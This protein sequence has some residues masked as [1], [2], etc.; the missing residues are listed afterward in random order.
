MKKDPNC[1]FCKIVAGEIPS[2][3]IA[4]N[5]KFLAILDIAQF[6]EGHTIVI[7]KKHY[8]FFWDVPNVDEYFKFIKVVGNNFRKKGF[9]Y[10]DTMTFG[11]MVSHA[12]VHLLPHNDDDEDWKKALR[13]IDEIQLDD[14]RKL[15]QKKGEKLVKKFGK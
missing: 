15:S 13:G 5:E 4:E 9:K 1:V 2:F 6:V 7:S 8:E 12:H 11:R 14:G 10:V 3:K